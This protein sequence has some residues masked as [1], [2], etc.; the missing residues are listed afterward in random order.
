M[1]KKGKCMK[2]KVG[3]WLDHRRAVIVFLASQKKERKVI[4]D[5]PDD[6]MTSCKTIEL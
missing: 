6:Q 5:F 3:L 4:Q 2:R 1:I